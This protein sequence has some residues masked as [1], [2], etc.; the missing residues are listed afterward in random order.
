MVNIKEKYIKIIEIIVSLFGLFVFY[1]ILRKI[2]GGSWSS[3]GVIIALLLFNTAGFLTLSV[4]YAELKSD[5]KHFKSPFKSLA[6]DFKVHQKDYRD[7]KSEFK[8]FKSEVRSEFKEFKSEVRSEFKELKSE[9]MLLRNDL[10]TF[11]AQ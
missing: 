10:K 5:L 6:V 7:S 8:E 1:Q 4:L 2:F 11:M 9:L 3:E